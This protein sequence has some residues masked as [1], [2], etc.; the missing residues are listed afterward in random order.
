MADE[1]R[2]AK[3]CKAM[4]SSHSSSGASG[5]YQVGHPCDSIVLVPSHAD[6]SASHRREIME[7]EVLLAGMGGQGIQLAAKTLSLAAV[8]AGREVML[9]GAYGGSMR[10][11]NSE[12]TVVIGDQPILSPPSVTRAGF[13]IG[14][15]PDY[16]PGVA[17]RLIPGAVAVVN[18]GIFQG[19]QSPTDRHFYEIDMFAVASRAGAASAGSMVAL[20]V[21]AALTS[22]VGVEDLTAS[23]PEALPPYRQNRVSQNVDAVLAGAAAVGGA[24]LDCWQT[25]E[26]RATT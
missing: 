23:I 18:S 3:S 25:G 1:I 20:G 17:A 15:H 12:S 11:G 10:G 9:F 16:W 5:R 24:I 8:A 6:E 21:L 22:I 13:A 4:E 2:D 7:K 14:M 19:N 26:L